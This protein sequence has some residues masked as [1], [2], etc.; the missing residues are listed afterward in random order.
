M[1]EKLKIRIIFTGEVQHN[2]V[3]RLSVAIEP[4]IPLI[5]PRGI[6]GNVVMQHDIS[7]FLAGSAPQKPH[8]LQ[9]LLGL[10]RLGR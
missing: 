3:L 2:H 9:S 5:Q 8:P 4:P 6:P 7:L 10:D 1:T